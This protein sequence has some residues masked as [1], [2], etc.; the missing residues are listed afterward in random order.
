M[1]RLPSKNFFLKAGLF[2]SKYKPLTI[3]VA[4]VLVST[5]SYFYNKSHNTSAA[6]QYVFGKVSRGDLIA[7]VAGSGQVATLSE[8]DIKPQTIGQ[9]QTLGQIISVNVKNGD[10]VRAGQIVA[11]LDGKAALQSLNQARSS[12]ESAQANYDKLVGGPTDIDLQSL[13]ASVQNAQLSL[14]N[15]KQNILIKLLSAYT[16]ASNSVYLSTDQF[17][18]NPMGGNPS[19]SI[20]GVSFNNQQLEVNVDAGRLSVGNILVNWKTEVNNAATSS[21][22]VSLLNNAINN[23]KTIRSYFDD[24]ANLFS[25]YSLSFSA[26]GQ[27][28]IGSDKNAASSARSSMD[29]SI[30]DLTSILQSYQSA[31]NNLDQSQTSLALKVAPP[32]QDDVTVSKSQLDNAKANL[33]NAE[34]T[35]SSR[36]ITA[37]FDGQIGGLTAQVGMQISSS[38]SL[39]KLITPEK[40]VNVTLNEVDAAK[41]KKGDVVTLTFDALP[42]ISIP[43]HISYLDPLGTVSQGVVSYGVQISMDQ[44]N[45]QIKT[46]MTASA[47]IITDSR[48]SVLYIPSSAITTRG[49]RKFVLV[50]DSSTTTTATSSVPTDQAQVSSNTV[51]MS[52]TSSARRFR[53][54]SSTRTYGQYNNASMGV[55]V[56][57][58]QSATVHQVEI[59]TGLSNDISTEVTSGLTEGED[60]VIRTVGATTAK[61]A[62]SSATTNTRRAGGIGG[63]G[64]GAV[65]AVLR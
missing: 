14:Q 13:K 35:Y 40:V 12:V 4:I 36:I 5:G 9:T 29:S 38:D 7:S 1:N 62:A 20:D 55:V 64:G 26:S 32:N 51:S 18:T 3:L 34:Q 46:G 30:S 19:L 27:S 57:S 16:S 41:V 54:S 42:D 2:A 53:N 24:M 48:S 43:G 15:A 61:S 11:V 60:I 17:F 25:S 28:A 10:V 44:Q 50:T 45:D 59:T 8:V 39:G 22:L 49:N 56:D 52:A 31:Q 37:P 33:A 23:I 65:G 21:D 58:T 6:S 63:F 47:A